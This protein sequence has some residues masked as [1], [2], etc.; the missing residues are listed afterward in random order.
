[1][2]SESA[3]GVIV[4]VLLVVFLG[5]IISLDVNST[6]EWK[7][8]CRDAGGVPVDS[9]SKYSRYNCW[10]NEEKGYIDIK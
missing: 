8:D 2:D 3:A 6:R 9:G 1:M 10:S 7:E 4:I 5:F